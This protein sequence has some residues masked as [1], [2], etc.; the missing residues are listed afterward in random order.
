MLFLQ[1]IENTIIYIAKLLETGFSALTTY[2]CFHICVRSAVLHTWYS[3]LFVLAQEKTVRLQGELAENKRASE[4][5]R[6][7]LVAAKVQRQLAEKEKD[8]L[9]EKYHEA[10]QLIC[11]LKQEAEVTHEDLQNSKVYRKGCVLW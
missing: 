2:S 5:D 8:E 1:F 6:N 4:A 11:R 10:D 7:E 3:L 9:A